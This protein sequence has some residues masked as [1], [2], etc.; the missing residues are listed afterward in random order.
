MRA[1]TRYRVKVQAARV[2]WW[3]DVSW[4][5]D[6]EAEPSK[7]RPLGIT[8][9]GPRFWRP[10]DGLAQRRAERYVERRKRDAQRQAEATTHTY[11][12]N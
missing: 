12:V 2:G 10:T 9:E 8:L 6:W 3:A 4:T 11:T 7:V 1:T 5:H